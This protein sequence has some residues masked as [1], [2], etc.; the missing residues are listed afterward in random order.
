VKFGGLSKM[1]ELTPRKKRMRRRSYEED[2]TI[3]NH[4]FCVPKTERHLRLMFD[5]AIKKP[6][7]I[8]I[9]MSKWHNE[10]QEQE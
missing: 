10:E 6:A 1:S 5:V 2:G 4:K 3:V 9:A 8:E 7:S